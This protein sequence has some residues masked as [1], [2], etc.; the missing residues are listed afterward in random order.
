[1]MHGSEGYLPLI[2]L[3]TVRFIRLFDPAEYY[4]LTSLV[5]RSAG[6]SLLERS[7]ASTTRPATPV[8][9][10]RLDKAILARLPP[11]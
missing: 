3:Q 10:S 1:M 5:A 9:T 8:A 11:S 2:D 4:S 6:G 7:A